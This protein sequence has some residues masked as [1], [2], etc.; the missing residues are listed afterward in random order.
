MSTDW[1]EKTVT[2]QESPPWLPATIKTP[3]L[4]LFCTQSFH[5]K[6][7]K[8]TSWTLEIISYWSADKLSSIYYLSP[9]AENC[10]LQIQHK[11]QVMFVYHVLQ[12][13]CP[14]SS[15]PCVCSRPTSLSPHVPASTCPR[16]PQSHVPRPTSHVPIQLLVTAWHEIQC[17]VILSWR[18]WQ[19]TS[20]I[21]AAEDP[22]DKNKKESYKLYNGD[23]RFNEGNIT[24][25]CLTSHFISSCCQGSLR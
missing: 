2:Y 4:K 7:G 12:S 3:A 5:G 1:P 23:M 24:L 19:V 21:L 25:I 6:M 9:T 13:L 11:N 17:M 15:S 16:V 8:A 18:T 14:L 20:S 22:K 10:I